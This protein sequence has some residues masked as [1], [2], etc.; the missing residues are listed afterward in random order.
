ML[1]KIRTVFGHWPKS[2][3][4]V[5]CFALIVLTGFAEINLTYLNTIRNNTL[6]YDNLETIAEDIILETK[7]VHKF[8]DFLNAD[9]LPESFKISNYEIMIYQNEDGYLL[10]YA[11]LN[12][13]LRIK[14]DE[15]VE[16]SH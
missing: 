6:I 12:L 11:D 3:G 13:Q 10:N 7:I 9:A 8:I 5:T 15:I 4:F 2:R 16:I 1:N 14:N